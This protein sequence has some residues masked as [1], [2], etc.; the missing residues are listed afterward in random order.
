MYS[1]QVCARQCHPPANLIA[2]ILKNILDNLKLTSMVSGPGSWLNSF[3]L[4]L[5]TLEE[6]E[7]QDPKIDMHSNYN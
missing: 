6:R 4:D 3:H 7:E 1:V 5:E 2:S